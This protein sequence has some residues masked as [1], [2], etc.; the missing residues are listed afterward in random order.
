MDLPPQVEEAKIVVEQ[1]QLNLQNS[2]LLLSQSVERAYINAVNAG[3]N[4][5]LTKLNIMHY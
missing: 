2:T 1:S 4:R 3:T 5:L